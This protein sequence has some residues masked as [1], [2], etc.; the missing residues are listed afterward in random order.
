MDVIRV[1]NLNKT[2]P[3]GNGYFQALKDVSLRIEEGDFVAIMG[4]SGAGKSTLLHNLRS[5]G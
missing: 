1:N 4:R 5:V 3:V 2:Y